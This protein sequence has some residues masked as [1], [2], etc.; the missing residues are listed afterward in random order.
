MLD[1]SIVYERF[2]NSRII[3]LRGHGVAG[4]LYYDEACYESNTLTSGEIAS[5]NFSI[6]YAEIIIFGSCNSGSGGSMSLVSRASAKG[7][8][9]VIGFTDVL[10][11]QV[12]AVFQYLFFEKYNCF[13]D[14][15]TSYDSIE[16]VVSQ[17]YAS[18]CALVNGQGCLVGDDNTVFSSI[19]I[20]ETN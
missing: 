12:F 8:P 9:I 15:N 10:N 2:Q 20:V 13:L 18:A 6:P 1:D 17:S 5:P 14:G 7:V 16:D 19:V 11:R 3:I 4:K